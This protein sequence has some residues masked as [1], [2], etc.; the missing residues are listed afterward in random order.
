[1]KGCNGDGV[2]YNYN[3]FSL[4][5]STNQWEIFTRSE[6]FFTTG[7]DLLTLREEIFRDHASIIIWKIDLE[8]HISIRNVSGKSA[9]LF[10]VNFPP[11]LGNCTVNP[12]NG[13]TKTLF[14]IKCANWIDKEGKVLNF[15]F[16]GK[17][18]SLIKLLIFLRLRK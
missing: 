16:Y 3:L 12:E 1:L 5:S 13:T 8:V 7:I 10:S 6:Y 9:M 2:T 18:I 15:A 11:R 17:F 14:E 4:N